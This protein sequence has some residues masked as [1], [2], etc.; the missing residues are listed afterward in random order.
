MSLYGCM[1][2]IVRSYIVYESGMKHGL[3]ELRPLTLPNPP[4]PSHPII[5][6]I[7]NLIYKLYKYFCGGKNQV[8]FILE[9]FLLSSITS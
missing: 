2:T 1:I 9:H 5:S 6:I 8:I 4:H 3:A 7:F